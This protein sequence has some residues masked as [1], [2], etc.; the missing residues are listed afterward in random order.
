MRSLAAIVAVCAALVSVTPAIAAE[1]EDH[2][3]ISSY[4]GSVPTRRDASEFER[5]PLIVGVVQDSLDFESLD[6]E[7]RLTRINY[8]NPSDRSAL[9]ILAN[10]E[11]AIAGV[12]GELLFKCVE[13]ECG[14]A[15]AGSRWGRFNDSIHLP[16]VGGYVA[17]RIASGEGTAYVAIGVAKNRHQIAVLEVAEMETGLVEIDPDALGDELDRLGHVAI[18]GVFFEVGKATLTAESQAALEAMA[19]ILND[20][21]DMAAWVVGH[22]DWT[23]D[24]S[25]NMRL[26]DERAKAVVAALVDAHGIEAGRLAGHGVGPL[27]PS[28]SN[29]S[30][31][32]RQANR[33]VELVV[34]P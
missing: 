18:P 21:P 29:A 28:A 27:A 20:R 33:R 24:M 10:Y 3:L 12:G 5:Y 1:I 8:Q 6:L 26:S 16:A 2:P 11:Q 19:T 7:G 23:G 17:G 13:A 25:L 9:E 22:T 14:P 34:A 4:P 15:F 32:G 30:E 31:P